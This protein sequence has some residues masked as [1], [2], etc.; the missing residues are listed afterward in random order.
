M[1]VD[2]QTLQQA[3]RQGVSPDQLRYY[4]QLQQQI[5]VPPAGADGGSHPVQ[6]PPEIIQQLTQM[7]IP[8]DQIDAAQLQGMPPDALVQQMQEQAGQG[9][10]QPPEQGL[11]PSP[12][13][14]QYPPEFVQ[15][16][17]SIGVPE[18]VVAEA[19]S[20]GV[21]PEILLQQV[22]KQMQQMFPQQQT[23]ATPVVNPG[24]VLPQPQQ[25]QQ[26]QQPAVPSGEEIK[27]IISRMITMPPD[28][29]QAY[30][31]NMQQQNPMLHSVIV[32]FMQQMPASASVPGGGTG[33]GSA[34]DMRPLPEQRPPRRPGA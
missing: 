23:Q 26:P 17:A 19:Q 12:G 3:Q 16:L 8:P 21:P 7:G 30:M 13:D 27:G 11:M 25:P 28:Q 29:L 33:G 15:Y 34:V 5:Q 4:M 31:N 10:G 22:Q 18:E 1:G 6:Y 2:V 32:D 9:Q 20:K 14:Q 24:Q